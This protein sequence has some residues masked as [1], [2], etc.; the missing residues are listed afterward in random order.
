MSTLKVFARG[1]NRVK[2]TASFCNIRVHG[3][4]GLCEGAFEPSHAFCHR[5][6][7]FVQKISGAMKILFFLFRYWGPPELSAIKSRIYD[8]RKGLV[9]LSNIIS[10]IPC[11]EDISL[12]LFSLNAFS[13]ATTRMCKNSVVNET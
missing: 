2:C 4:L 7:D 13:T 10:S 5:A 3:S 12:F 6:T 9:A 11:F 1:W 8:S